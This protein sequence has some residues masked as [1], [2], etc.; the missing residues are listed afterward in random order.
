MRIKVIRE[1]RTWED[2][3]DYCKARHSRLLWIEDE[4]DQEAVEQWLKFTYTGSSKRLWIG[5]KQS[6]VFG[7]WIWSDRIVNYKNWENGKQ[8]EMPLSNHC[9]VI[10]AETFEWSDESCD[11]RLPFLCEEDIIYM[12]T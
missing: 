3:L 10:D 8:P 11:H 9:G 6:S 2:A 4:E 7:F 5:L 1:P 12:K